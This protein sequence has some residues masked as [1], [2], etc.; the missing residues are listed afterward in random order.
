MT[1]PEIRPAE[2][3]TCETLD[4]VLA[5]FR[6]ASERVDLWAEGPLTIVHT[7][8]ALWYLAICSE[9]GIR[10]MCV[11]YSDNGLEI[12]DRALVRGAMEIQ[13]ERHVALDPCL[14]SPAQE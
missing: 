9:P 14:A 3:A 6:P 8:G 11:A 1:P 7:D 4:Q 13:D 2:Y 5:G 10:V 12:G